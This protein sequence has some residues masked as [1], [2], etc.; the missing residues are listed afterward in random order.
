MLKNQIPEK[1]NDPIGRA[2]VDFFKYGEAQNMAL[3][4]KY[5]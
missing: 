2:I 3:L 1:M 5:S 4:I